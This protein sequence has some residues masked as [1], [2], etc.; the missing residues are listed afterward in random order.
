MLGLI[1]KD[2]C[3]LK[4]RA[5]FF[6]IL[7]II[8]IAYSLYTDPVFVVGYLIFI[9]AMFASSTVSYDEFDNCYP[10]LMTLPVTPRIY[11]MEKYVFGLLMTFGSFLIS[12]ALYYTGT[13]YQH[14]TIALRDDIF[15]LLMLVPLPMVILSILLPI[16]FKF[17]YERSRMIFLLLG[18]GTAI[19]CFG[20]SYLIKKLSIT[21][22]SWIR[23]LDSLTPVQ[24]CVIA[25]LFGILIVSISI[26]ISIHFMKK[27]E[28]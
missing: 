6:I 26:C 3:L 5:R 27:K 15:N 13:I 14:H 21:L 10:F 23:N 11:V 4:Q 7:L 28:L 8:G 12:C 19:F 2:I 22:P 17:G 20:I 1:A 25:W 18:G 9:C 16:I 24:C